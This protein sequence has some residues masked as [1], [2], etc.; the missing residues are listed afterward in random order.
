MIS[1]EALLMQAELLW[2][3]CGVDLINV[4]E[5]V[6]DL[7]LYAAELKSG[8]DTAIGSRRTLLTEEDTQKPVHVLNPEVNQILDCLRQKNLQTLIYGEEGGSKNWYT[9]YLEF[10]SARTDAPGRRHL[11]QIPAPVPAPSPASSPSPSSAPSPSD[12][13]LSAQSPS[14]GVPFSKPNFSGSTLE[15]TADGH[16]SA[17][18]NSSTSG[19]T[20][21]KNS[22]RKSVVVAVVVTATLSFFFAALLFI[23]YRCRNGSGGGRN[24]ERPL[25]SLSLSDYSIGRYTIPLQSY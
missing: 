1:D 10:F 6:E 7:Q 24:D 2:V 15:P 17:T 4:K 22:N 20:N 21:K 5:A 12:S 25:L 3:H 11:L 13:Q 9:K 16:S 18:S 23:C 8:F 14:P 19:Q